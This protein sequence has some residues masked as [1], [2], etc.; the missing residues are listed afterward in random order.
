MTG[1]ADL[2]KLGALLLAV[3]AHTLNRYFL[4]RSDNDVHPLDYIGN[5]V[6]G[7]YFAAKCNYT[8][9]FGPNPEYIHGVQ[10]LPATPALV[11]VRDQRFVW[12]GWQEVLVPIAKNVT[13]AWRSILWVN[14]ATI[15][16]PSHRDQDI[17]FADQAW[18]VLLD[19]ATLMDDG[20]SRSWAL[21]VAAAHRH[22]RKADMTKV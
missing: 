22:K 14:A 3:G 20:L 9:W 11:N 18:G 16:P 2:A 8:T 12:E 1:D 5:K 6:T 13:T 19:P 15:R 21:Y 4:L 7:I 17:P 10:M